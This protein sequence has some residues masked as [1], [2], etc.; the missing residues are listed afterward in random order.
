[1]LSVLHGVLSLCL[2]GLELVLAY[3]IAGWIV[4][5]PWLI[6]KAAELRGIAMMFDPRVAMGIILFTLLAW[7]FNLLGMIVKVVDGTHPD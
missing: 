6:Q 4:T 5:L 3:L 7:P 1:M 2:L